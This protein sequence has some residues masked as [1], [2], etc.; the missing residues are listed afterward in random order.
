MCLRV[1]GYLYFP[2]VLVSYCSNH[3]AASIRRPFLHSPIPVV[4]PI[5]ISRRSSC[6]RRFISQS[7]LAVGDLD[8]P[9][10]L[11]LWYSRRR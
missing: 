9:A 8:Y 5:S 4:A 2:F 10:I 11:C 7:Y 1:F 6:R 3:L